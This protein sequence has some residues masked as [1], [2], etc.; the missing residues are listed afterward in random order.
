MGLGDFGITRN[1]VR[2]MVEVYLAGKIEVGD[3]VRTLDR[4]QAL[5]GKVR[6]IKGDRAFG[7]GSTYPGGPERRFQAKVEN[8]ALVSKGEK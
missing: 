6:K 3:T 7:L 4:R 2:A 5:E 1:R 8:L